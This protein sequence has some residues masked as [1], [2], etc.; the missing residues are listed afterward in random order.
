MGKIRVLDTEV[1]NKIA[2]GEVVERPASVVKE[3]VENSIDAGANLITVEIKKGGS[4]YI[5]VS[6]N[7]SGMSGDDAAICFLRHAT[8]KIRESS[9][10]DAIYTLGFRGEALSSI[11]AVAEVK[12]YTK[13]REDE[14]GVCVTCRG[15]EILSSDEAGVPDGTS[16]TV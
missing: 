6:D 10:L 7:G 5:R 2:A 9:D 3:L 13:R 16:V 14:T 15:G 8:S 4:T 12:L 11:G 1:S